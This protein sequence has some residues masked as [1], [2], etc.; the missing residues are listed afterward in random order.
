MTTKRCVCFFLTV[1]IILICI[2][3]SGA[4][5]FGNKEYE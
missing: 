4:E 1:E 5:V 2:E 3:W